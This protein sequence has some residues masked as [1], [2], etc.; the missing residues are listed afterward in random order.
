MS[1]ITVSSSSIINGVLRKKYG[2]PSRAFGGNE[3]FNPLVTSSDIDGSTFVQRIQGN[4]VRVEFVAGG[5]WTWI[6]NFEQSAQV[7]ALQILGIFEMITIT[8]N[9]FKCDICKYVWSP[10]I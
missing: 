1:D 7:P 3:S 8:I 6:E 5:D 9:T 10:A 2:K 4:R